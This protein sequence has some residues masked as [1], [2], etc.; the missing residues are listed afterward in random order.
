MNDTRPAILLTGATGYVGRRLAA[1]LS[2][3]WRVFR[4]SRTA[5]GDGAL[6]LNLSDPDSIRR[7]FLAVLDEK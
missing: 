4:A 5:A 1:G 2:G 3:A 7:A 6:G